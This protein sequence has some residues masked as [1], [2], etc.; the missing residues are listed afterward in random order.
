M[1]FTA[2]TTEQLNKEITRKR[3]RNSKSSF[4]ECNMGQRLVSNHYQYQSVLTFLSC[5]DLYYFKKIKDIKEKKFD[6]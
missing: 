2:R 6:T 3:L 4:N 5:I 1:M